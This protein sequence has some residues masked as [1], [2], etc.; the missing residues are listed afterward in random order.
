MDII[1]DYG[2][3][4]WG[5]N[6]YGPTTLSDTLENTLSGSVIIKLLL[7]LILSFFTFKVCTHTSTPASSIHRRHVTLPHLS[8]LR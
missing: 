6:P 3:D 8:R 2:S 4:V 7:I 1:S 5:S